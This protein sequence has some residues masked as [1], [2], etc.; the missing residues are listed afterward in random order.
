MTDD[1]RSIGF[2]LPSQEIQDAFEKVQAELKKTKTDW[3]SLREPLPGLLKNIVDSGEENKKTFELAHK[4]VPTIE[5]TILM[6]T[7]ATTRSVLTNQMFLVL[8][9]ESLCKLGVEQTETHERLA[10]V[11][12]ALKDLKLSRK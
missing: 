7:L 6:S 5:N 10:K 2:H 11:E 12:K 3:A 1:K 8:L 9:L 4:K